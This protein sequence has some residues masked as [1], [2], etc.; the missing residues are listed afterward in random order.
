MALEQIRVT[1]EWHPVNGGVK[2]MF[3]LGDAIE[4]MESLLG[5]WEGKIK[6]I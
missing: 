6:L 3:L 4:R 2:G 5:E 1:T